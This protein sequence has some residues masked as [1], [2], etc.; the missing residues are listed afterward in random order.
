MHHFDIIAALNKAGY[1]QTRI[2]AHLRIAQPTVGNVIRG[3]DT[4]YD[5]ATFISSVT[6]I[7]M[8]RMWPDGRYD[9]P[10]NVGRVPRW[11]QNSGNACVA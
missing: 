7:P 11:Q 3:I 5:V 4:S 10:H 6:N 9:K 1:S 2:A 8:N